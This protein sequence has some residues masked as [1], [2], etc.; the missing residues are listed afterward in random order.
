MR[1]RMMA[2][3]LLYA[4]FVTMQL[5]ESEAAVMD[6][7]IQGTAVEHNWV[8]YSTDIKEMEVDTHDI[9]YWKNLMRYT[10]TCTISH[11]IRTVVYYCDIHDHTKSETFLDDVIHSEKHSH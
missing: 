6:K 8:E 9:T 7:D 3:S 2:M 4:F 5:T 1:K 10:R 11:V